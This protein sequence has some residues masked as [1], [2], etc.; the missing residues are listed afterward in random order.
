LQERLAIARQRI[1]GER[2]E[3]IGELLPRVFEQSQLFVRALAFGFQP[4]L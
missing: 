3:G 1:G 4:R 2:L